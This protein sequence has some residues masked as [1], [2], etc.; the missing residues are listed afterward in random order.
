[1]TPRIPVPRILR[2]S[3]AATGRVEPADIMEVAA[4]LVASETPHAE[5]AVPDRG[6]PRRWE[7]RLG[8]LPF[9]LMRWVVVA[10]FRTGVGVGRVPVRLT[11]VT[12]RRLGAVGTISLLAGV[13]LGLLFAPVPGRQLRQRLRNL[14][15]TGQPPADGD[16]R[17]AVVNELAAAPRTAHLPQPAVTVLGGV[18]TL[19]GPAPTQTAR[20]ELEAVAASVA[21]VQGV[22]NSLVVNGS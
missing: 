12:T 2:R 14:A 3:P 10:S 18:V 1:M 7:L 4:T 19:E 5:V 20:I 6:R 8:S 9:R 17:T 21:G 13:A 15:G 11:A 22:V 16:V